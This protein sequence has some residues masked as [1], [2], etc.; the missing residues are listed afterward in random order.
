M[1]TLVTGAGGS[2]GKTLVR[3][4]SAQGHKVALVDRSE[5]GIRDL[6]AEVSGVTGVLA[7]A[8]P[9]SFAATLAE[10]EAKAGA[11]VTGA[12]LVAGGWA[13]GKPLHEGD[14]SLQA[15]FELNALTVHS[16]LLGLLP[17]MV[18]RR[19]GSVVVVGSRTVERPWLGATTAGYTASKAAAVSLARAAAAEVLSSRVRINAVLISTL[20]TPQNRKSM[21]DVD[22]ATWVS[23]ESASAV[24]AFLLSEAARDVSG[25][26]VPIYGQA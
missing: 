22:P 12:A 21:P 19:A 10:C 8:R 2:L 6:A 3:V 1:L 26:E 18:A 4:L 23:T 17:G 20:D 13:G 9:E 15:M 11:K 5:D 7:D 16:A 25:A 24:I 14:T